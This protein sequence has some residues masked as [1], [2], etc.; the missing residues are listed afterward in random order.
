MYL[1]TKAGLK[2]G[3]KHLT[4][5][6]ISDLGGDIKKK[7]HSRNLKSP[8]APFPKLV[9]GKVAEVIVTASKK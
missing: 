2:T 8:A 9:L 5:E 6:T 1:A 3:T 4:T 7:G